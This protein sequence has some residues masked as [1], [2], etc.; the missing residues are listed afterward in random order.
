[1]GVQNLNPSNVQF[2]TFAHNFATEK[3]FTPQ[4]KEDASQFFAYYWEEIILS[5]GIKNRAALICNDVQKLIKKVSGGF[6]KK[7]KP[8]FFQRII[9]HFK[10]HPNG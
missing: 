4:T 9:K 10:N 3:N 2:V 6:Y 1:M 8:N 5:Y 7:T